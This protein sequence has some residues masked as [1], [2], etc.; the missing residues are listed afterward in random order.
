MKK[1]K[2]SSS[3]GHEIMALNFAKAMNCEV[4]I[5]PNKETREEFEKE[6]NRI[7]D[8]LTSFGVKLT[9]VAFDEREKIEAWDL[10]ADLKAGQLVDEMWKV[11]AETQLSPVMDG[12]PEYPGLAGKDNLLVVPQKLFS[13]GQCGVTAQQQS[14]PLEVFYFLKNENKNLVLGQHFHKVNDL[15]VVTKLA[16]EFKMYV[17]GMDENPDVFGIRG[18]NHA[19]YFNM[20][21]MLKGSIGIAGTHTW[22]ML[23]CFPEI[24]QIIL[25][26]QKGVERWKAIETAFQ[27]AGYKI[28]CIG[29]DEQTDMEELSRKVEETYYK[30]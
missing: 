12:Q 1:I 29:F 3:F 23:T 26:N 25:F 19:K 30:F 22:I 4:V 21:N 14:L 16:E 20:Y 15:A 6:S 17:P 13:D 2:I 18:V 24:P 10:I 5:V 7:Y 8:A 9:K 28:F 11:F 27:N